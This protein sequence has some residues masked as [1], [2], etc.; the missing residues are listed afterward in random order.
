MEPIVIIPTFWTKPQTKRGR[1]NIAPVN[2]LTTVY[3]HPT[4]IDSDGTLP[5]C[6]RSLQHV[7]GLGKVVIIVATTDESIEHRAEDKVREIVDD[8]PDIDAFV[9]GPAELGSLH[10]RLEQLEFADMI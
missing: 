5:D 2:D 4:P 10:R 9:F 8:F 1:K 7:E 6:L 3:D